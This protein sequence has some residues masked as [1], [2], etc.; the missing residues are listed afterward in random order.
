M[1]P[2]WEEKPL[3]ELSEAEWESLCDG[4]ARC[5]MIKMEDEETGDV[6][7]TALVCELLDLQTC[8]C[9]RYPERH[10]LV[11]DCIELSADLAASLRWLPRSCAYRR[12]AEGRGLA[13]W[14]PLVSGNNHSVHDAGISVRGKVIP[15]NLVHEDEQQDHIVGWV[16]T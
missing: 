2:F 1:T 8:R 6:H 4:C 10:Q 7:H 3:D 12:V 11:K 16:E 9:T 15:V 13:D 14:H 5:C